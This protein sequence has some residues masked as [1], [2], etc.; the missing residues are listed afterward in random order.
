MMQVIRLCGLPFET[1]DTDELNYPQ[2]H[3]R[4]HAAG[5]RLL[6]LRALHHIV[7]REVEASV[8][9]EFADD[10]S[11]ALDAVWRARLGSKRLYVNELFLTLV[12]R[13]LQGKVGLIDQAWPPSAAPPTSPGPHRPGPRTSASWIPPARPCCRCWPLRCAPADG[14]DTDNGPA[15]S[16]WSSF[17]PLQRRDAPGPLPRQDIASTCPTA[18]SGFGIEAL[19]MSRTGTLPAASRYGLGQDY[20]AN[21]SPGM[22]DDLLRPAAR[23][24]PDPELRLRRRQPTLDRMNLNLRR[25]RAA[26]TRRCPCAPAW[27]RPRTTS[28]PAAPPMASTTSASWSR[29]QS[30]EHLD[31]AVGEVQSAFTEMGVISV[32]EDVI[33]SRPFWAQFPGNFKDIARRAPDL[34]GQFRRLRLGPHFPV[35]RPKQPLGA[36]GHRAGDHLGRPTISTSTRAIWATSPS[37]PVRLGGR[38]P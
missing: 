23:D 30:L 21:S 34:D 7:R 1:A 6:A 19:E 38:Y 10:F 3:P 20:P 16:R 35:A 8:D 22:L 29:A 27:P 17:H 14:Y 2:G 31:E 11:R 9:G 36:G 24:D 33:W 5:H 28:P 12:R 18:G 13:P 4:H 25:M 26:T 37:S 15:R 32:R